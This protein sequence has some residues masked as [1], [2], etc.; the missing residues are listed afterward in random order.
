[1]AVAAIVPASLLP[2]PGSPAQARLGRPKAPVD[3]DLYRAGFREKAKAAPDNQ[4]EPAGE[5]ELTDSEPS[6]TSAAEEA[7]ARRAYP[8]DFIPVSARQAARATWTRYREND[9]KGGNNA[10]QPFLW[11]IIGPSHATMPGLLTFSGAQYRTAGR[12]TAL[13]ISPSCSRNRCRLWL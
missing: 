1:A 3:R 7:Y 12:I 5:N 13:A 11:D 8:L 2:K 10:N 6:P 9:F 4:R